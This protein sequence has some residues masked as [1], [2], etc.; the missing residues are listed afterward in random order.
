MK[1]SEADRLAELAQA[2]RGLVVTASCRGA[3]VHQ[4]HIAEIGRP[5]EVFVFYRD[6]VKRLRE[7]GV[8]IP[9]RYAP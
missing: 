9:V 1:K 2:N 4:L 3:S 6:A 8:T 7:H 5:G